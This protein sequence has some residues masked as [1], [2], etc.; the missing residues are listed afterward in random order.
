MKIIIDSNIIFQDWFLNKPNF[1]LLKKYIKLSNSELFIPEIVIL[2][3]SNIYREEVLKRVRTIESETNKL[4]R[5]LLQT[6]NKM[7]SFNLDIEQILKE[8]KSAFYSR[9]QTLNVIKPNHSDIPHKDVI[10]RDI[11]RRRPFQ[12]SGKGYR[13][14]LLWEVIIQKIINSE[15]ET[16]FISGNRRDFGCKDKEELHEH[17]KSDIRERG[18]SEGSIKIFYSIESF[19]DKI[20]KPALEPIKKAIPELKEGHFRDF[21]ILHWF[22]EY[23][24]II[25][26]SINESIQNIFKQ[27]QELED[28][29]VS[30][31][32]EPDK[33]EVDNIYELDIDRIYVNFVIHAD[34]IIDVFIFKSDYDWVSDK[35]P[36][37]VQ[38]FN[39][40]KHYV[41]A[42]ISLNLPLNIAININTKT[43]SVEQFEIHRVEFEYFGF[44]PHC[45]DLIYSDTAEFCQNCKRR[46]VR[47]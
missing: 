7:I 35:Y 13:D 47:G 14:T 24:Q 42:Q 12:N 8:Y 4:N 36:I 26:D 15:E 32:D 17:L 9:L 11:R 10:A 31:I 37:D 33:I 19:I 3:S 29:T 41:W 1:L 46:L 16:S 40:N 6:K 18:L 44:C 23:H 45:G 27:F 2:E 20:V 43:E 25:A 30:I 5:L 28:P 38:D 21:N 22:Y 34:V 39:W